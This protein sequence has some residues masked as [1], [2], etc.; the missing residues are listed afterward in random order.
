[1]RAVQFTEYGPPGVV[2]VADVEAPHAGPGEIRVAVRV[3]GVAS[4][5]VR[6]RSGALREVVPVT[7]PFRTGFDAAGVVDEVGAGVTGVGV[8][9][10]VFG[11]TTTAMRG[12]NADFAILAAWA[13]KPAAWSWE[14]AGGAAGS[15]ETATRVLDRLAV[16][17]GHTVLIQ[18][19][20]GAVGTIAVQLAVGRGATVIGTASE[21]NHDILRALGAEPTTYGAGLAERVRVLAPAG[22]DAVFDCAGGSLPDLIAIAGDPARVVT[23]ADLTAAAYGVHLSHGAPSDNTG[24]AVGAGADPLAVHGLAI[25]VTLAGEG[26]LRVPVAAAFPLA[27]AA[28]AHELSE[29]RHAPG[30]IVLVS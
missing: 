14:E 24:A 20:A 3:S 5:E 7:F 22:V 8:G 25:A 17:A 6:I 23:I 11:M 30:K 29:S 26:R 18:G 9:D 12:A 1:M 27:E 15:V 4:G 13:P 10:E 19:A 2:H 16:R 28:A 21:H